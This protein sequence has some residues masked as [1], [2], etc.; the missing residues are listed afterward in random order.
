M[1]PAV[2]GVADMFC[3][4]YCAVRQNVALLSPGLQMT[5]CIVL[6]VNV[7]GIVKSPSTQFAKR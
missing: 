1:S 5:T 6:I 2:C 7:V 4:S 3:L